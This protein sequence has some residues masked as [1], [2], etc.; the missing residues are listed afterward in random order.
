MNIT[1]DSDRAQ[2]QI[3]D[4]K[5]CPEPVRFRIPEFRGKTDDG[6]FAVR[7]RL[8][9]KS[10]EHHTRVRFK[11]QG[12]PQRV[13]LDFKGDLRCDGNDLRLSGTVRNVT[14]KQILSGHHSMLVDMTEASRFHDSTGERTYIYAETGWISLAQLL[15]PIHSGQHTIR[16]GATYNE[17][18]VMWKMIARLDS[19]AKV[20]FALALDKG[21]AFAGDHP[22]W[23]PGLLG[24]YRWGTIGSQETKEL[25]GRI[26]L[27]KGDLNDLRLKYVHDFK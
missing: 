8:E 16:M 12:D 17:V 13:G 23:T 19:T 3:T 15:N 6:A 5:L 14:R 24:G 18:T 7:Q 27:F 10:A 2:G 22:E 9:W 25:A 11:L 26:Y 1:V 20:V 21:Y 4:P